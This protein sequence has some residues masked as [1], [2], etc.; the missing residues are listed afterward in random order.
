MPAQTR[1]RGCPKGSSTRDRMDTARLDLH[2]TADTLR[3]L[4]TALVRSLE[5]RRGAPRPVVG[6]AV[7][8][9]DPTADLPPRRAF[10][11]A[12]ETVP[13]AEP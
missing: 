8:G 9:V 10:F 4:T 7:Y 1:G 2:D 11:A 5:R 3:A 6:P 12:A 13:L